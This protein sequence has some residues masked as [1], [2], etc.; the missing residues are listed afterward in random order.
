M[1]RLTREGTAEPVSRD[2]ILM[3]EG[4]QRNINFPCSADHDV[5][6]WQPYPVGSSIYI[7]SCYIYMLCVWPYTYTYM[8]GHTTV[9]RR[10]LFS[11]S[12]FHLTCSR[13]TSS[14]PSCLWPQRI[15]PSLPGSRLTI[16]LS[17]C[18]FSTLTTRQPMVTTLGEPG[19][20]PSIV[21]VW[22]VF[23][24][25]ILDIKFVGRTSRGH[26]GGR[27]HRISHPS[28]FCCACLYFSREKDSAIPFPCQP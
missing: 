28:S 15:F 16:F 1:K 13:W 19:L 12:F 20:I 24:P 4:G 26:S 22:R 25:F 5:Q 17:R 10:L 18:K 14:L 3:H 11:F 7:Y 9:G 27:S 2:Q 8:C 21:C 6:D 23:F